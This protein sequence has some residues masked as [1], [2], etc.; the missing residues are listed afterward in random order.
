MA[1]QLLLTH[2]DIP[3]E[4]QRSAERRFGQLVLLVP[5][6][7]RRRAPRHRPRSIPAPE[8]NRKFNGS[9]FPVIGGTDKTT[10]G[11]L[12]STVHGWKHPPPSGFSESKAVMK[13]KERK[14]IFPKGFRCR[15]DSNL[16][17]SNMPR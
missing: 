16:C 15:R 9:L 2:V 4:F 10:G 3:A 14:L 5:F 8:S 6:S 1:R 11:S 7:I 17:R 13:N 12:L